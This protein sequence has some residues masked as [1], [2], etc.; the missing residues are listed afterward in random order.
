MAPKTWNATPRWLIGTLRKDPPEGM[1]RRDYRRVIWMIWRREV[2]PAW[3][4][5]T[6]E[7]FVSHALRWLWLVPGLF[8]G[9]LALYGDARGDASLHPSPVVVWTTILLGFALAA[10]I[11]YHRLR[12]Q[13]DR[14]AEDPR[15]ALNEHLS[16]GYRL[17]D[18]LLDRGRPKSETA[19]T[20]L[21]GWVMTA[22]FLIREHT[23]AY[24]TEWRQRI[25]EDEDL[26]KRYIDGLEVLAEIC[27][28]IGLPTS[29]A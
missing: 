27:A 3:A 11:E 22:A 20:D 14:L 15:R 13:R 7:F 26:A 29:S 12:G 5:S 1:A 6:L 28:R 10:L 24:Y 23:P 19:L 25:P 9:V 16:E 4:R 18:R 21:L 17:R 8:L 2:H